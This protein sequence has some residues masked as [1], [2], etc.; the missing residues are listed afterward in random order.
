MGNGHSGG[1]LVVPPESTKIIDELIYKRLSPA[2]RAAID[3]LRQQQACA[4]LVGPIFW[5]VRFRGKSVQICLSFI[6]MGGV[7]SA[8][9][10][11]D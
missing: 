9:C 3:Q 11:N 1:L 10:A 8:T 2:D 5:N 4:T 7:Y 6:V